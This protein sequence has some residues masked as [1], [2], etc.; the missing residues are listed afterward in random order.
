MAK[1]KYNRLFILHFH[2]AIAAVSFLALKK[3]FTKQTPPTDEDRQ[4]KA[5]EKASNWTL[6]KDFVSNYYLLY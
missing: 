3:T 5:P 2:A 4:L 6:F 1:H